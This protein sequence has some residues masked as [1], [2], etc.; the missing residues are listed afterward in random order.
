VNNANNFA[1][2]NQASSTQE[3]HP[4]RHRNHSGYLLDVSILVIL[5]FKLFTDNLQA[6]AKPDPEA[7]QPILGR[8]L[9]AAY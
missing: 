3:G 9:R 8:R 4:E 7:T 2:S 6:I 5:C 1:A